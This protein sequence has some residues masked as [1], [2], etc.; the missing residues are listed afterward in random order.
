MSKPFDLDKRREQ[1]AKTPKEVILDGDTWSLPADFPII[2]AEYFMDGKFSAAV[3]VLFGEGNIG[4]LA[5]LLGLEMMKDLAEEVYGA[6]LGE[7][8]ASSKS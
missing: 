1:N 6:E 4:R 2:C 8:E 5:P 7:S 3:G